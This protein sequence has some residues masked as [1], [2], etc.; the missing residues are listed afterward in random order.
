M[1]Q[2]PFTE[3]GTWTLRG[4]LKSLVG[5]V[6][7]VYPV[8]IISDDVRCSATTQK[9]HRTRR[10]WEEGCELG[11][12]SFLLVL[13]CQQRYT[14]KVYLSIPQPSVPWYSMLWLC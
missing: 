5:A 4:T 9:R 6:F 10:S 1:T 2:K 7:Q 12:L 8:L 14:Y 11:L 13:I 3:L